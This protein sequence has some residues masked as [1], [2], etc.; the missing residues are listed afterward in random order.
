MIIQIIQVATP[1]TPSFA[2]A[3]TATGTTQGTAYPLSAAVNVVTVCP[4][5]A[6]VTLPAATHAKVL[7][8]S[9]ETLLVYPPAAQAIESQPSNG[10]V[11]I[12]VNGAT[13][14]DYDGVSTWWT[15]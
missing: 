11:E 7:N 8:R 6:G 5:G 10:P 15:S 4:A 12:G 3:L 2:G 9:T 14:F 1:P 13:T